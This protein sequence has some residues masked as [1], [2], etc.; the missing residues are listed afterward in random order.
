MHC[1]A[2]ASM[3]LKLSSGEIPDT[4]IC[5][6]IASFQQLQCSDQSAE[7]GWRI[8]ELS[9]GWEIDDE[10]IFESEHAHLPLRFFRLFVAGRT[11]L[12]ACKA[13]TLNGQAR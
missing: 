7:L 1:A 12:I 10:Q 9:D 2:N 6:A 5:D 3:S 13:I 4:L 8:E 11:I